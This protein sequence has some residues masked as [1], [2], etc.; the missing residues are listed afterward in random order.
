MFAATHDFV[1]GRWEIE[2]L[3][4]IFISDHLRYHVEMLTKYG[5]A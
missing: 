2:D 5:R 3:A 4:S 1:K